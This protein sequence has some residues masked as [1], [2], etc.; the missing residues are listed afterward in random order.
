M[1]QAMTPAP[2]EDPGD[3]TIAAYAAG[4]QRYLEHSAAPGPAMW[5]YLDRLAAVVG[6]GHV[7][8]LGSGPGWDATHLES[9]GVRV[10]RTDATP[11][12]VEMLH[13][14]GHDARLLDVRTDDF[15]GP[16]EAVLADAMLLHLTREQ[17]EEVLSRARRA[18]VDG[19]VLAFTVKE[20]DGT[21]WSNV[22]LGLPRH[23]TYW[24][25]PAVRN[26]LTRTG[27]TVTSLNH[28]AGRTEPWL[29]IIAHT[30][31]TPKPPRPPC[32]TGWTNIPG[33][34]CT[35]PPRPPPG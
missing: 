25:E 11:A 14:A 24:R 33:S 26:V 21:A 2:Q 32:G 6:A 7:L 9:R 23:L 15:G 22:K 35:S 10:T 18:V 29:Y 30:A 34:T 28:V 20:G 27:W 3:V 12:F 31:Q 1:K 5:T 8:E 19:G 4:V 17:F 13:A 16:Y